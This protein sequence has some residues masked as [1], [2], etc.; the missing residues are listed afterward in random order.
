[1]ESWIRS[2]RDRR[3]HWLVGIDNPWGYVAWDD[4]IMEAAFK[5][6]VFRRVRGEKVELQRGQLIMKFSDAQRRWN[7]GAG[8]V[9]KFFSDLESD[10]MITRENVGLGTGVKIYVITICNYERYQSG[11]D[12]T[13]TIMECKRSETGA[14]PEKHIEEEGN[15][16]I[17]SH[18][19]ARARAGDYIISEPPS[20]ECFIPAAT[21]EKWETEFPNVDVIAKLDR[22]RVSFTSNSSTF[23]KFRDYPAV[24]F[25]DILI[26][27][28]RKNRRKSEDNTRVRQTPA[29]WLK[30]LK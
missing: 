28:N 10:G 13:G 3:N 27:E 14:K 26:D 9:A 23:M 17:N 24:W 2:Y 7:A 25:R 20:Y 1:M 16:L 22:L 6:G 18:T 19:S 4:M 12:D 30:G 15:N 5:S 21:I 29:S 8:K 11:C